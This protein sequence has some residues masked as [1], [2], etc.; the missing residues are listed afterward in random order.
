MMGHFRVALLMFKVWEERGQ[1]LQGRYAA[2]VG[3]FLA[4][5]SE[6]VTR[7]Q[8]GPLISPVFQQ[9]LPSLKSNSAS[10]LSSGHRE[11]QI[12]CGDCA[13]S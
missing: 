3:S 8:T 7:L 11:Q 1:L 9:T 4:S 5:H 13:T 12:L 2:G 10:S 6:E